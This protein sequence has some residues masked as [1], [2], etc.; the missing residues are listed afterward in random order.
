MMALLR[1]RM[2]HLPPPKPPTVEMSA[3]PG[4]RDSV[5]DAT[6]VVTSNVAALRSTWDLILYWRAHAPKVRCARCTGKHSPLV[7]T[8]A[9]L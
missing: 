7:L 3:R 1:A 2:L 4:A 9:C 8:D 6:C 5:A